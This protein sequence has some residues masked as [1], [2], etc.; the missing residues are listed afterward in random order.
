MYNE[1]IEGELFMKLYIK[2]KFFSLTDSYDIFD[3]SGHPK[4]QAKCDFTFWLHALRVY[5]NGKEIGY[6]E[7]LLKFI[8]E[9]FVFYLDGQKCGNIVKKMTFLRPKYFLQFNEWEIVGDFFGLDYEV[10]DRNGNIVMTFSKNFFAL[11]DCY[12]L[13]IVRPEDEKLCL[14]IALAVDMAVCSESN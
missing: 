5:E 4:Y 3:E 2:Q 11:T 13:D 9:E 8:E 1:H 6:I 7:E 10:R 14:M 12:C